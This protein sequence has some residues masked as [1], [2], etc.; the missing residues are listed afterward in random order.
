M[1]LHFWLSRFGLRRSVNEC[2]PAITPSTADALS[3]LVMEETTLSASSRGTGV[4]SDR[5]TDLARRLSCIRTPSAVSH[6]RRAAVPFAVLAIGAR[7][8]A[9]VD[10]KT[11]YFGRV[12]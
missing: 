8:S 7:R 6:G 1:C 9:K 11:G 10:I 5:G 2:R 3:L 12:A 4:V